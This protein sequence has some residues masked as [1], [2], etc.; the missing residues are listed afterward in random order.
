[1]LPAVTPAKV[2]AQSPPCSTKDSP[3]ATLAILLRR[4]SHSPA[5]TSGGSARS[6]ATTSA[7]S[8]ASS[9]VGCCSGSSACSSS[10]EGMGGLSGTRQL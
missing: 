1:M 9:Y 8:A 4:L 5:N 10:S 7:T 3:A 2:S 6:R